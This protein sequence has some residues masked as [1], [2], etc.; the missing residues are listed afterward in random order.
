MNNKKFLVIA[1]LLIGGLIL[2]ACGGAQAEA[3]AEAA[4]EEPAAQEEAAPAEAE[5]AAAAVEV[6]YDENGIPQYGCLGTA[7]DALVDLN[8]DEVTVAVENA[9]LPFNYI[10]SNTHQAGGWDYDVIKEICTRLHCTPVFQESS[11]DSMIQ[12]VADG[13]YDMAGDG[14]TITEERLNIVDFSDGYINI[15]QRLLVNKGETR[16]ASMEDFVANPDLIMGTQTA[17][18]NYETAITYLPE[19]R[20][21]AFEQFPIAIQALIANDVDAVIIDETAGMGYVGQNSDQLELIGGSLSSDALGFAFP[22]GSNLVQ[23]FNQAIQAM[24][25][26]GSLNTINTQF[27]GPTF[28]VTYDDIE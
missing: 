6:T 19:S 9:Y 22:K 1:F 12:S 20:V 15:E 7:E 3:A 27:F 26:D 24:K 28:S 2:S 25:D 16:F 14:I 23:P 10:D 21:S 13:L 4:P 18:T 17:T 8:C 5:P 11:W